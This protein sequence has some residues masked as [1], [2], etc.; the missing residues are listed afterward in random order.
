MRDHSERE[1]DS[2][3]RGFQVCLEELTATSYFIASC[4][5]LRRHAAQDIYDT[6]TI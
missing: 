5:I 1:E 4:D 3:L 6:A 2:C